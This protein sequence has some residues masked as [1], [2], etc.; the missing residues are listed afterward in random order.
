MALT[1]SVVKR[2]V[3][4][5][6]REAIVDVTFDASYPTGGLSFVAS[7]IDPSAAAA[8]AFDWVAAGSRTVPGSNYFYYDYTNKKLM[9]FVITT[10]VEVGNGVSLATAIVRCH[11]RYGQVSG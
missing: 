10:G 4:G 1:L 8:L 5:A 11:V 2:N 6:T 9:A 3:N 7:D